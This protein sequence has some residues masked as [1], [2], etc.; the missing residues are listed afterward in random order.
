VQTGLLPDGGATVP[1]Y[2]SSDR[3]R[4]AGQGFKCLAMGTSEPTT[5]IFGGTG[6]LGRAITRR[7]TEHQRPVTVAARHPD[8]AELPD[9][10]ERVGVDIRDEHGVAAAVASANAVVNVV[11]LYVERGELDFA[12][13]HVEGAARLARLAREAGVARL[14]HVSGIGVDPASP[15]RYVR[16]R[17]E[18]ERRVQEAFPEASILRPSVL[19]GAGDSFLAT[20]DRVTRLPVIPLFGDGGTRLQPAWVEDVAVAAV[21]AAEGLPAVGGVFELGGR[22]ILRYRDV[23]EAVLEH[24]G[25]RRLLLPL[26]WSAWRAIARIGNLVPNPPVTRDQIVL[27]QVDNVVGT[28]VR[29]FHDLG[30]EPNGFRERLSHCLAED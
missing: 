2:P 29:T 18:G 9:S 6:F 16:A 26:P 8:V 20:L 1:Q 12:S 28:G 14:V 22:D 4:H 5:V 21:T 24:R 23:I 11:S 19:F 27:M 3:V 15:S 10:A 17:A 25:R 30:I 7:L 13:I